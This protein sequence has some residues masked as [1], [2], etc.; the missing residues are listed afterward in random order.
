MLSHSQNQTTQNLRANFFIKFTEM[1]LGKFSLSF[2]LK[3]LFETVCGGS[4]VFVLVTYHFSF[5]YCQV[6]LGN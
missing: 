3:F 4:L 2:T 1:I 5:I 6:V